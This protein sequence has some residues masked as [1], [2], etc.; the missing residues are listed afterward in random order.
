MESPEAHLA[1]HPFLAGMDEKSAAFLEGCATSVCYEAGEFLIREGEPADRLFLIQ[2]GRVSLELHVGVRGPVQVESVGGGD[3]LGLS[4][5]LESARWP[6]DGRAL[7]TVRAFAFD[8][9]CLQRKMEEDHDVGYALSRRLLVQAIVRL[10]RVRLQR[11]DLY[12]A[13]V[14]Q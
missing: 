1:A 4:W 2:A 7:E 10:E 8:A 11:L 5:L 6:L 9:A 14:G 12:Q 3:I 13:E